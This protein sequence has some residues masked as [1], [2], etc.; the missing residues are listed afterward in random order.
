MVTKNRHE[1]DVPVDGDGKLLTPSTETLKLSH[2]ML[3]FSVWDSE[4]GN[5]PK[6]SGVVTA[7]LQLGDDGVC[8]CIKKFSHAFIDELACLSMAYNMSESFDL[9][10]HPACLVFIEGLEIN[11]D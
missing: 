3:N 5:E 6:C 1:T 7:I 10:H 4:C 9:I 2:E 8:L 11:A